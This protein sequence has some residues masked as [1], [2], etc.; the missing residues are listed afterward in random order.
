MERP[1]YPVDESKIPPTFKRTEGG[2]SRLKKWR[3]HNGLCL[4]ADELLPPHVQWS[5]YQMVYSADRSEYY[6][7][8][9]GRVGTLEEALVWH[10]GNLLDGN[11]QTV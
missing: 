10:M 8:Y 5:A 1:K 2:G 3:N 7:N 11:A 9:W 6:V 4:T